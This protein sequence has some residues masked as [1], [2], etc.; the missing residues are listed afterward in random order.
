MSRRSLHVVQPRSCG[1]CSACCT[2]MRI[3]AISKPRDVPCAHLAARGCGI[4]ATRPDEC[5]TFRCAWLMATETRDVWTGASR[6]D[7][8]GAV[9]WYEETRFGPSLVVQEMREGALET[10]AVRSI[11]RELVQ[12][13]SAVVTRDMRGR[14]LVSLPRAEKRNGE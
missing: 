5:R 13:V 14:E 10:A 6:P 12:R 3:D 4:Y 7:R 9:A 11:V 2:A 8:L 1:D